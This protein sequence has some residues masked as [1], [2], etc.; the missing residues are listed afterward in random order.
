MSLQKDDERFMRR[1]L[2]EAAKG[3][4]RTSPNP[5]VGAV[6]VYRDQIVARGYHARPG[7]PHAE[8]ACLHNFGRPVP[9]EATLYV[10]LE[11]CSTTGRTAPCTDELIKAGL[12]KIVIGALDGNPRHNGK[13]V[14]QLRKAG[15]Q[16]RVGVLGEQCTSLNEAFNKWIVTRQPFVIAKCGMSLD[17]RLS[18]RPGESR[19]ITDPVA[20]RHAQALRAQVD[21]ILIGAETLRTDDPRLTVRGVSGARQPWRVVVTRSGKL[22]SKARLFSD[23]WAQHTLVYR[24]TSLAAVLRDLGKK[25]ITSVLLEGGGELLGE[26]FDAAVIDKVQIYVGPIFTGGPVPALA[27]RGVDLTTRAPQLR[28]VCYTRLDQNVCVTGYLNTDKRSE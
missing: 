4:G 14:S 20:R 19:W 13:G 9:P 26:A 27:G 28:H 12:Q 23:R 24:R 25:E 3:F 6:L 16:I 5:A 11:P 1:A 8:I 17:G 15:L 2:I 18:R 7:G 21:A 22:P 10:T